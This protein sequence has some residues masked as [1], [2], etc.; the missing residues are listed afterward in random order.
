MPFTKFPSLE[1]FGHIWRNNTALLDGPVIDYR[2]KVKLH[3]TNAAIRC[4]GGEVFAQ[5]RTADITPLDDN[6]G[7]AKWLE[8]NKGAWWVDPDVV[9]EAVTYFGEWAG[10]GVQKGDA[11]A[12]ISLKMFFIFAMQVGD[13]MVTDPDVIEALM[14]DGPE[15]DDVMV[16]PWATD[17]TMT[18]DFS[19]P[20]KAD[21]QA[22]FMTRAAEDVGDC[23]PFIA[24]TFGIEAPGEGHV[25]VPVKPD[26]KPFKR[27]EYSALTFKVKA[28]RHGAKKAK[29]ASRKVE[30]PEG[31]KE[32]VDMFVT[33]ARCQ[34]ALVEA[35]DGIAE[36]PRTPDFLKWIGADI[37]KESE[38][39]LAEAG[40][41]WKQVSKLVN[42]AAVRWFHEKCSRPFS[43]AA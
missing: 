15:L 28:A 29:A 12:Q 34:Q 21:K 2:A 39:E 26:H 42:G 37:K 8:P 38:V 31:A 14:P 6:A 33:E 19:A 20:E 41:E 36:K 22:D 7:F 16:L 35:C 23:D 18:V 30:I 10:P 11:V 3:G 32:F 25:W 27:D 4:E 1:S 13:N 43:E 9:D 24:E 5:K 40:L 17:Y